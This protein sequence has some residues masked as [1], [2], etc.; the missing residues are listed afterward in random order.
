[1][2]KIIITL[3]SLVILD[4]SGFSQKVKKE[5]IQYVKP[6]TGT[7]GNGAT[8]AAAFM[9]FGMVQLGPDTRFNWSYSYDDTLI[10][11]FSHVHKSGGGCSD[12]QDIIFFP[13]T[14]FLTCDKTNFP[15]KSQQ[16]VLT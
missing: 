6:Y 16:P 1:M 9:P 11:G 7:A 15:E 10:Y 3:L 5:P 2:Q 4:C 12:Y 14:D 8:I 13:T